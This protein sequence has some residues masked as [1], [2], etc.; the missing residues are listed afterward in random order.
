MD[1][2][3]ETATLRIEAC[4]ERARVHLA[5]LAV[6]LVQ[7]VFLIA[8]KSGAIAGFIEVAKLLLGGVS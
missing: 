8:T 7:D 2:T 4:Q 3:H 5:G 1:D 6:R